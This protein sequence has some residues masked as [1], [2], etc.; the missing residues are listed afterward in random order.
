MQLRNLPQQSSPWRFPQDWHRQMSRPGS[1]QYAGQNR[2]KRCDCRGHRESSVPF[3][4]YDNQQKVVGTRRIT[5]TPLL[6]Q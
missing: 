3:S 5:P 1:R 2:Q 4:Y 6:K